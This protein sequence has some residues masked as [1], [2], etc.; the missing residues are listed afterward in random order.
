M[1]PLPVEE[2]PMCRLPTAPPL[3][4]FTTA[5]PLAQLAVAP[6]L[7]ELAVAPPPTE[8]A[9]Q[10]LVSPQLPKG[11]RA[12]NSKSYGKVY[13]VNEK[14]GRTQWEYPEGPDPAPPVSSPPLRLRMPE[15]EA[16]LGPVLSEKALVMY[17]KHEDALARYAEGL[18]MLEQEEYRWTR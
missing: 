11:W 9:P 18:H 13:Y 15:D 6:P 1:C 7:A 3:T 17:R 14:L 12:R 2:A 16:T 10:T 5:P 8:A 4:E